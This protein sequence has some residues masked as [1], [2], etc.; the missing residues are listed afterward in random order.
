[1]RSALK[2]LDGDEVQAVAPRTKHE[3]LYQLH[4][5]W[6]E[7]MG[8]A[9]PEIGDYFVFGFVRNPWERMVSLYRY[10]LE[11]RPRR[12]ID[13]VDSF[14][15]FLKLAAD[16]E[17]W[18]VGLHSM[19]TQVDFFRPEVDCQPEADFLG[20]FEHL[21]EDFIEVRQH[22]K[23]PDELVLAHVN[24][25]S[26]SDCDYREYYTPALVDIVA[27]RF[28]DDIGVFGYSFDARAPVHRCSGSI[29][30]D[31]TSAPAPAFTRAARV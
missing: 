11:R 13:Q 20:H 5:G 16:R 3:T 6:P 27:E 23:L 30:S 19:R 2:Y 26:N 1:M 18:V 9:V 7:R 14:A 8:A 12:E 22:L 25:S 28:A 21:P 31:A 29:G 4:A 17:P 24:R 10:L 15:H